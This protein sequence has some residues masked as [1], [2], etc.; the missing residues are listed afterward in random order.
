MINPPLIYK[1]IEVTY[2][3]DLLENVQLE[4]ISNSDF[5]INSEFGS[6]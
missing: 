2:H 1:K 5:L 3:M 4:K 6:I